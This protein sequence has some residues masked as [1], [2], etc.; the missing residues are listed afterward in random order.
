MGGL[1][2]IIF[3]TDSFDELFSNLTVIRFHLAFSF[4]LELK[5]SLEMKTFSYLRKFI[6]TYLYKLSQQL[7]Y[8]SLKAFEFHQKK[9]DLK[10]GLFLIL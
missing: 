3:P 9:A 1:F 7:I 4:W 10:A 5:T 6:L 2:D 8:I